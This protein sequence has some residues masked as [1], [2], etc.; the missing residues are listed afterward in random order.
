MLQHLDANHIHRHLID[1]I[2]RY[3]MVEVDIAKPLATQGMDSLGTMELR[4]NVQVSLGDV[5]SDFHL[6]NSY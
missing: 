3:T 1:F 2:S 4:R 6:L 5:L